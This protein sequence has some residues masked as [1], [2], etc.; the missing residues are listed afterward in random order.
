[1]ALLSD[2][3][4]EENRIKSISAIGASFAISFLISIVSGPAIAENFGFFLFLDI[5]YTIYFLYFNCFFFIPSSQNKILKIKKNI[6]QKKIK[7][8]FKKIFL[9]F[10]QVFFSSFFVNYAFF[11]YTL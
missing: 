10:I 5:F 9:D 7:Y 8:I 11:D 2:L 3:I 4:R 1:M 6:F